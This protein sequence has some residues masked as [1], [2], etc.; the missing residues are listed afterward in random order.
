MKHATFLAVLIMLAQGA[1][2]APGPEQGLLDEALSKH[3]EHLERDVQDKLE[4]LLDPARVTPDRDEAEP[5]NDLVSAKDEDNRHADDSDT[6]F[7]IAGL[8]RL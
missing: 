4:R 6:A 1:S 3:A 5:G 8:F 2:A 7:T